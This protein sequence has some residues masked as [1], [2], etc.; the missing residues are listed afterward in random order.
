MRQSWHKWRAQLQPHSHRPRFARQ[1]TQPLDGNNARDNP[2]SRD[3]AQAPHDAFACP[4]G[5]T[6]RWTSLDDSARHGNARRIRSAP[7][8]ENDLRQTLVLYRLDPAFSIRIQVR[9][10]GRQGERLDPA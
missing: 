3:I 6:R 1:L 5:T 4:D 8:K 10:A 9:T 2:T 7:T